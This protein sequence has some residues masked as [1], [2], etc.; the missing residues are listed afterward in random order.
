MFESAVMNTPTIDPN[1]LSLEELER[2]QEMIR[3]SIAEKQA[4]KRREALAS[5][6]QIITDSGLDRREVLDAL[7]AGTKRRKAPAVYRNPENARQ[8]WSGLG[9]PPQWYVDAPDKEAIKIEN[10]KKR[11]L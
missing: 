3:K 1:E 10:E 11:K 8:T 4:Q 5:I 9:T 2:Q 6:E 7:A